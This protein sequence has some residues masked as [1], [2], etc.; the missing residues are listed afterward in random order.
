MPLTPAPRPLVELQPR[1]LAP[2]ND[3]GQLIESVRSRLAIPHAPLRLPPALDSAR[4]RLE[5]DTFLKANDA[6][7]PDAEKRKALI[8]I[9]SSI[10]DACNELRE[11]M[12]RLRKPKVLYQFLFQEAGREIKPEFHSLYLQYSQAVE[13]IL[14]AIMDGI[15]KNGLHFLVDENGRRTDVFIEQ[16]DA[17]L[18]LMQ[19]GWE[20]LSQKPKKVKGGL[21]VPN[22]NQA[23]PLYAA[24]NIDYYTDL[25][26]RLT[27]YLLAQQE[28]AARAENDLRNHLGQRSSNLDWMFEELLRIKT[29]MPIPVTITF[30]EENAHLLT[31]TV[32][33][34]EMINFIN[35]FCRQRQDQKGSRRHNFGGKLLAKKIFEFIKYHLFAQWKVAA[36]VGRYSELIST[37]EKKP[38]QRL[39]DQL[40]PSESLALLLKALHLGLV[41]GERGEQQ[42]ACLLLTQA[43]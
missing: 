4:M 28:E 24:S 38:G 35:F 12:A 18:K 6:F 22:L 42:K 14:V 11:T 20:V 30:L 36:G 13:A 31:E 34:N 2:L 21:S 10:G 16:L 29:D 19:G 15:H 23:S 26:E 9:Y 41:F 32:I 5:M 25:Q 1:V 43:D 8:E 17:L 3:R 37:T 7:E 39:V 40:E 33:T 27:R